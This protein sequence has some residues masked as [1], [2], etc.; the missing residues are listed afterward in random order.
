VPPPLPPLP[1]DEPLLPPIPPLPPVVAALPDAP[2]LPPLPADV[3]D[4][5]PAPVPV[6][7]AWLDP[8]LT[9][10]PVPAVVEVDAFAPLD[11]PAESV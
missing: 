11:P 5:P 7:V 1:P 8:P 10:E 4:A 3:D 9:V 2:A 6:L